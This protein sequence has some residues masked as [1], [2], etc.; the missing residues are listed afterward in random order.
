MPV[1]AILAQDT[2]GSQ[3]TFGDKLSMLLLPGWKAVSQSTGA[4]ALGD[5]QAPDP[6]RTLG[7]LLHARPADHERNASLVVVRDTS[8]RRLA[9][10]VA[11][12][13]ALMKLNDLAASQGY[14]LVDFTTSETEEAMGSV[15]VAEATGKAG[16]GRRRKFVSVILKAFT[17]PVS[18]RCLWQ[19]DEGDVLGKSEYDAWLTALSFNHSKVVDALANSVTEPTSLSSVQPTKLTTDQATKPATEEQAPAL[20][21]ADFQRIGD[22]VSQSRDALVVIEGENGRG[23]GFLCNYNGQPTFVTNIHVL[24]NNPSPRYK[25]MNGGEVTPGPGF[26]GVGHDIFRSTLPAAASML[27]V[28]PAL[29]ANVKIGDKI[30]VP[31]NAEGAGVIKPFEGKIVGIGPNL[32]EVDAPFVQGNSGSPIIHVDS[33]KVVGIATYLLIKKVDTNGNEKDGVETTVRRFGF[34]LD[35]VPQWEEVNW[36]RFYAQ[37]AQAE[38]IEETSEEF[39]QLFADAKGN[40]MS[41]ANYKNPGIQRALS[42]FERAAQNGRRMSAADASSAVRGLL[43]E[44]RIAAT[45]DVLAFDT[46]NAYDYFKRLVADEKKF[47]D[48]VCTGFT[49]EIEKRR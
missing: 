18:V 28:E 12:A 44:L 10:P 21:E 35:N 25:T 43:G 32:I 5:G 40:R 24:S 49:R 31:G 36:P 45:N 1:S 33:G 2:G 15:M 39:V 37:S 23:S 27:E 7:L 14:E 13:E 3:V 20:P 48:D 16:D 42:N 6:L 46:R 11:R 22:L 47:R 29:D 4:A 19:W 8:F 38:K 9:G 17:P 41:S 34:R 26:L 30:V